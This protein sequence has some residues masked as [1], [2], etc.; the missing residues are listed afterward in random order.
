MSVDEADYSRL[1]NSKRHCFILEAL[2]PQR[3]T[4]LRLG[5]VQLKVW[6]GQPYCTWELCPTPASLNLQANQVLLVG[7]SRMEFSHAMRSVL[8][9]QA[10]ILSNEQHVQNLRLTRTFKS[11]IALSRNQCYFAYIIIIFV[12]LLGVNV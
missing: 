11:S 2:L 10:S 7:P 6:V 5:A 3:P 8:R 9:A 1:R 4:G 12:P